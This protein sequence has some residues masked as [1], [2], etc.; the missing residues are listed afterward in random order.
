MCKDEQGRGEKDERG[1]RAEEENAD[2]SQANVRVTSL[3]GIL[4]CAILIY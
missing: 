2:H 4:L 3:L 1:E